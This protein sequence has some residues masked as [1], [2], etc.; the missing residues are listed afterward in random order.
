M[1]FMQTKEG[2]AVCIQASGRSLLSFEF[3][4]GFACLTSRYMLPA[5]LFLLVG[6][7]CSIMPRVNNGLFPGNRAFPPTGPRADAL[8]AIKRLRHAIDL[9]KDIRGLALDDDDLKPC[10]IGS[11]I[12]SNNSR[13]LLGIQRRLK[14]FFLVGRGQS[15]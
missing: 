13:L 7:G 2:R 14:S 4:E 1:N 5:L 6:S 3:H 11:Q 12:R 8:G 9:D 10:G 15:G